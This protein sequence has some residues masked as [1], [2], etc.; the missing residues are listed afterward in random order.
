MPGRASHHGVIGL[1]C[2]DERMLAISVDP[3]RQH[4]ARGCNQLPSR[5]DKKGTPVVTEL[6]SP[7]EVGELRQNKVLVV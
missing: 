4:A 5:V 1:G 2:A 3:H 7:H 6:E